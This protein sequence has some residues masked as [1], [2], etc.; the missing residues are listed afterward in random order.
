MILTY[1][2]IYINIYIFFSVAGKD[3][4]AERELEG[5]LEWKDRI[6][7]WKAKQDKNGVVNKD[8]AENDEENNDDADDYLL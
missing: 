7:K 5:N 2:Y 8:D 1:F 4:E 3:L 6:E